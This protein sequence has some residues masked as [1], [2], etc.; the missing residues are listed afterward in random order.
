MGIEEQD[1][2]VFRQLQQGGPHERGYGEI[3]GTLRLFPR[4]AAGFLF[5][6]GLRQRTQVP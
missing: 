6:T 4:P 1:M 5:A 2:I 3:K